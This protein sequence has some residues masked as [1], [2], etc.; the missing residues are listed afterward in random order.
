MYLLASI[1]MLHD[2][3]KFEIFLYSFV[4]KD[5]YT[6]IAQTSGCIF[7]DIKNLADVESFNLSERQ[8]QYC[9]DQ[10]VIPKII[11]SNFSLE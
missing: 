7:K 5:E 1:L 9:I 11:E 6:E 8:Y 10:W 4:L 2:K 3:S